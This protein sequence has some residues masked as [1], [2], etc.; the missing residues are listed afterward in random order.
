MHAVY[1]SLPHVPP[2][3][4]AL[5]EYPGIS[6][7]EP[8]SLA[9]HIILLISTNRPGKPVTEATPNCVLWKH[10]PKAVFHHHFVTPSGCKLCRFSND[11][12]HTHN[13]ATQLC[14]S[15]IKTLVREVLS[16]E[17]V[18]KAVTWHTSLATSARVKLCLRRS[19]MYL[20]LYVLPKR[21]RE[22]KE[23][24]TIKE[25]PHDLGSW[26]HTE[27][28][29]LHTCYWGN[30]PLWPADCAACKL[31]TQLQFFHFSSLPPRQ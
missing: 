19:K 22:R 3:L 2:P 18:G 6:L 7:P 23:K 24:F 14:L 9:S 21:W 25:S 29:N 20:C 16:T 17:N 15:R 26:W 8:C 5:Q 12:A 4:H 27:H 1:S 13:K 11:P 31:K 30:H 10:T 28:Q